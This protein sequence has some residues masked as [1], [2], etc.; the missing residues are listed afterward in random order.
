VSNDERPSPIDGDGNGD[1]RLAALGFAPGLFRRAA[2]E[3]RLR[4]SERGGEPLRVRSLWLR[5]CDPLLVVLTLLALAALAAAAGTVAP[6]L[7]G[8]AG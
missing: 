3:H 1:D 4:D 2:L 6:Q 5:W 8:H 7:W